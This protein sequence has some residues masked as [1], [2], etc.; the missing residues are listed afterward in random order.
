MFG[1]LFIALILPTPLL[2][3]ADSG[4]WMWVR[5][6][7]GHNNDKVPT[8]STTT[9]RPLVGRH[10]FPSFQKL[11]LVGRDLAVTQYAVMLV[12]R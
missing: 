1:C 8:K 12:I 4:S 9:Q 3:N 6:M 11:L 5:E 2:P 7:Y 10:P